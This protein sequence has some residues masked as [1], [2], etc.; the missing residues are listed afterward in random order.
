MTLLTPVSRHVV[1]CMWAVLC[2]IAVPT[3]Y[4]HLSTPYIESDL[5]ILGIICEANRPKSLLGRSL[6]EYVHPHCWTALLI[7]VEFIV[8]VHNPRRERYCTN[9]P[10]STFLASSGI[11][12]YGSR[13]RTM[14]SRATLSFPVT[15]PSW[16]A[17]PDTWLPR[18]GILAL[19]C[20]VR[21]G[22]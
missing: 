17:C 20:A 11:G 8:P 5:S 3:A 19:Q 1:P 14:V 15:A 2:S 16:P 12:R 18:P 4:G 7:A 13:I 10:F 22:E 6:D 9:R 21:L